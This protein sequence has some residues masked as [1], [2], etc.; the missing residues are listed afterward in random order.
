MNDPGVR[1][2]ARIAGRFAVGYAIFFGIFFL[3]VMDFII[4]VA[5]KVFSAGTGC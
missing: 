5:T 2:G 1:R 3:A 4:F